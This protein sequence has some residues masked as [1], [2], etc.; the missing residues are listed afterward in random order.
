MTIII[1]ECVLTPPWT[2]IELTTFGSGSTTN[3]KCSPVLYL[4]GHGVIHENN[5]SKAEIFHCFNQ[6]PP[7]IVSGRNDDHPGSGIYH[8]RF[9]SEELSTLNDVW[10]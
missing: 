4:I 8:M 10:L 7:M 3:T 2:G 5:W 6:Y 1:I 9:F